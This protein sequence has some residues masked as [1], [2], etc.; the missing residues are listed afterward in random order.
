MLRRAAWMLVSLVVLGLAGI[1]AGFYGLWYFGRGLPDY[2][3]LGSYR[4]PVTTRIHGA[5]GTLIAELAH[6]RRLFVPY[7]AIPRRVIGAFLSAEDKSFWEHSG[8]DPMGIARAL[9]DNLQHVGQDR[10]LVGASTITQQVAKNFLLSNEV[11]FKRKI[12][13]A[14]LAVRIEQAYSKEHILELYLN[15]IFLGR[16]A[17]GV[18]AAALNYFGKGLDELTIAEAAYLAALPKAPNNYNPQLHPERA[19]ERR[20]WVIGRMEEDGRITEAEAEAAEKEPLLNQPLPDLDPT[21][22]GYFVEEVRREIIAKFGEAALY[23]SGLS[24]RTTVRPDLQRAADSALRAGLISYDRRHGWRGPISHID[25]TPDWAARLSA[26]DVEPVVE[27]WRPAVVLSLSA[28][29]ARI[30]FDDGATAILPMAGMAWARP[31][32]EEQTTGPSPKQPSD[33]LKTG[34]IIVVEAAE[35]VAGVK[36][37]VTYELRQIPNVNGAVVAMDPHTGRVMALSGGFSFEKSQYDRATQAKRQPGSA[38]K[39]FVYATSLDNGFTPSSLILDAPVAIDQG[40]GLGVWKPGNYSGHFYGPTT[41]RAGLELS[42]NLMTVRLAQF[43]GMDKVVATAKNFGVVDD[44]P[45]V[46]AMALGAGETT[47]MRMTTAY[48]M[49]VNGGKRI[50]PSLIDRAQDRDGHD[51]FSNDPRP[52]AECKN[53][54]WTGQAAPELPDTR[55]S[56]ISPQTAYQIVNILQGV[57]DRGTAVRVKAVGHPLAGKT[58][59]SNDSKDTWFVGFSPDLAV[60]VFV[61]F[62]T[63]DTLGKKET[64]ASAAAPIFRDFMTVALAGQAPQPFRVPPGVRLVRIDAKTGLPPEPGARDVIWEAYKPGTEPLDDERPVLDLGRIDDGSAPTVKQPAQN[65]TTGLY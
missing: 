15:E 64:G 4:P 5:D 31:T 35:P 12:R 58:G 39:P 21:G 33:V 9:L 6:E 50:H 41:L 57:V 8:V 7:D 62:D 59:T 51:I 3:Q 48:A 46:L 14:I 11:S 10:R 1:G 53:V 23:E 29:D 22:N 52:C 61:G 2:Q 17:Y 38:F 36:G 65:S 25:L 63:P 45:P 20:N 49:F 56:V 47:L 27:T 37:P 24:I 30:G 16:R 32:L 19:L 18:A 40:P 60:G 55:E 13:E 54:S 44:I 42:R 34:D 26:L 43:V 28:N